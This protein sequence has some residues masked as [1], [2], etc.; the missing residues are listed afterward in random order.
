MKEHKILDAGELADAL[1]TT[2]ALHFEK[3]SKKFNVSLN[4]MPDKGSV[5]RVV[6][7][8]EICA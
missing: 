6:G 4:N 3:S 1:D 8:S 2:E 5:G 7:I